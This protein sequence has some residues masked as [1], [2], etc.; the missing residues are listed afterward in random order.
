MLR[1]YYRQKAS[2]WNAEEYE[3]YADVPENFTQ[4]IAVNDTEFSE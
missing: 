3:A 1:K 4:L 2:S